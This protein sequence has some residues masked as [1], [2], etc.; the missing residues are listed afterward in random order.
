MGGW[1]ER[2]EPAGWQYHFWSM[3]L[4]GR[5]LQRSSEWA[6]VIGTVCELHLRYAR[7]H[8]H[9]HVCL[10]RHLVHI[11]KYFRVNYRHVNSWVVWKTN[12][13]HLPQIVLE[14]CQKTW[15]RKLGLL[16]ATRAMISEDVIMKPWEQRCSQSYWG[17]V[18][19]NTSYCFSRK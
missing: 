1:W 19:D 4:S 6:F 10:Q 17:C 12:C 18:Y 5:T 14:I 9:T 8:T 11:L 3:V 15:V 13:F 16:E 2:R 7:A